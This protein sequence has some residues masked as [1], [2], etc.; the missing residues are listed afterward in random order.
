M[1]RRI[2]A[3]FP[4]LPLALATAG[5]SQQRD[6]DDLRRRVGRLERAWQ[7]AREG[8]E[9]ARFG[10]TVHQVHTARVGALRVVVAPDGRALA[11]RVA[12]S[13]WL[14]LRRRFGEAAAAVEGRAFYLQITREDPP[15]WTVGGNVVTLTVSPTATDSAVRQSV[16]SAAAAFVFSTADGDLRAW[17]APNLVLTTAEA[18]QLAERTYLE[19][20]LSPLTVVRACY[21]GAVSACRIALGLETG[22]PVSTWYDAA[23]RVMMVRML[24]GP[25]R[26][27]ADR[28]GVD[29][30]TGGA[31]SACR[32]MLAQGRDGW[33]RPPLDPYA[34]AVLAATALELGA[35]GAFDRMLRSRGRPLADRLAAAAQ[36][37][38]D[39]LVAVWRSRAMAARP[40]RATQHLDRAFGVGAAWLSLLA[41]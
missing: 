22:D 14:E 32:R 7:T 25:S 33:I 38:A 2:V 8:A 30:C 12:E 13:V 9:R 4:V 37:S 27:F 39:S 6:L 24:D 36:I 31:D 10:D 5:A 40:V 21:A 28:A 17:H 18:R 41:V 15:A 26:T 34:R 19:L 11:D 23:D 1:C 16:L 35:E 3:A 29:R 20:A